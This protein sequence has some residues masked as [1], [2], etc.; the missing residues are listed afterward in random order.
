ML[1]FFGEQIARRIEMLIIVEKS[2]R[3]EGEL[4]GRCDDRQVPG[5]AGNG[6]PAPHALR[7]MG[8]LGLDQRWWRTR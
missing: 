6:P 7:E 4:A 1:R 2:A 5:E 8:F 3:L